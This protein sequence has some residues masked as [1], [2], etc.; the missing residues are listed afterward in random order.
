MNNTL[1]RY[2]EGS[3]PSNPSKDK[4]NDSPA[5]NATVDNNQN[6]YKDLLDDNEDDLA[7]MDLDFSVWQLIEM[8][9]LRTNGLNK[10]L[11][12]L[13]KIALFILT[14]WWLIGKTP[15]KS[16]KNEFLTEIVQIFNER[17]QN[18]KLMKIV[19]KSQAN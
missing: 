17:F 8:T 12:T 4:E 10:M 1:D 16:H 5:A 6:E 19:M 11:I 9:S 3:K 14:S 15:N 7:L 13:L 2:L 18:K